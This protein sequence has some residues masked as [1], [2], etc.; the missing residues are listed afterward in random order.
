MYGRSPLCR[1]YSTFQAVFF[2]HV[3]CVDLRWLARLERPAANPIEREDYIPCLFFHW[4]F[5]Y[6]LEFKKK[7]TFCLEKPGSIT[8]TIPSMVRE[9]SAIFV[10]TIHF[11]ALFPSKVQELVN[12]KIINLFLPIIGGSSNMSICLLGGNAA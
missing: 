4:L 3:L 6:L 9:V 1:A 8:Y 10:A 11:R 12:L 2:P 5:T 7:L